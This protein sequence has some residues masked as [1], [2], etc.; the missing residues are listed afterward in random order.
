MDGFSIKGIAE[1][2]GLQSAIDH[3]GA[4]LSL[5][6]LII[7]AKLA[8]GVFRRLH[9]N[10]IVAYATAGI[11]LGPVLQLTGVWWVES[12]IHLELLLTLGVFL[13]FFLIGIDEV[14]ISSFMSSIRGRYFIAAI[15]S[16]IL[17]LGIS[18]LVTTEVVFDFGLRLSFM[19]SLALAGVLSMTSLGI[20]AKVLADDGQLTGPI[21][22]QI[23]TVVIIAELV[24]LLLIGFSIG[25]HDQGASVYGIVFL[26]VKIVGFTVVSWFLMSRVLPPLIALVQRVIR[27][28]QLAL[29]LL[30]GVLFLMVFGAELM[31]LHGSLGALLF[32]ASLSGLSHQVRREI[33]P[34]LRGIAN[35]LFVPLFFASAGLSFSFAFVHLPLWTMGGLALIPLVGNFAGAFIGAFVSRLT[36][37]YAVASGLLGKGVAEIALL[38]VLWDSGV[39]D[40]RVFSFLV[41]VMFG[42][43][44][45]MP[46][47]ISYTVNRASRRT[48]LP[49]ELDDLPK[50]IPRFALEDITV[51]NI[52]DR[53][54][55]HPEPVVSVGDL[56]N[57][58]MSPPQ[59]DYV[60]A[61]NGNIAGIVSVEMLRYLPKGSWNDTPLSSVM[62]REPPLARSDEH[63]E[64][65]LQRMSEK[66]VSVMPVIDRESGNFIGSITRSDIVE[67]MVAEVTGEH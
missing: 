52:L 12:S 19:E 7:V 37:P 51:D 9:Q 31:G 47:V 23:F 21:G 40:E 30:L 57:N 3:S 38:L 49:D 66:S 35:G 59:H 39:I 65:V 34:G 4:L 14:D 5:G 41:L 32:G 10:A 1:L 62:R 22:L 55:Q 8:E 2:F 17:S 67:F 25:E 33:V 44:F 16:V 24:V 29:G 45:V 50:G 26:L 58:W 15:L 6:L 48:D 28:P 18:L 46:P 11:L 20:V 56:A 64:D 43:I 61:D 60:V 42:Y 54:M 36:V 27:V 53:A 13:F 63:I